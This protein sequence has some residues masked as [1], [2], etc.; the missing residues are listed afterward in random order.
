MSENGITTFP[1]A[2][3]RG[4]DRGAISRKATEARVAA[5]EGRQAAEEAARDAAALRGKVLLRERETRLT[6]DEASGVIQ[7]EIY[8]AGTKRLVVQI[9]DDQWLRLSAAMR[10]FAARAFVDKSV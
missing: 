6:I 7:A 8:D 10:E 5:E 2:P 9:P 1:M 4:D 3:V